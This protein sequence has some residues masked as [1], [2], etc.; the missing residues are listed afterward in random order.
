[1]EKKLQKIYLTYYNLLIAQDLW[2]AHYQILSI[3]FLKEFIKLNVNMDTIIQNVKNVKL[4][5]KI[6][7]VL[8][9]PK[10]SCCNKIY[11]Q[12]FD[13][14]LKEQFFNIY[15]FPNHNNNDFSLLL[16]KGIYPYDK[17]HG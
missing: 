3:I 10:C 2:Q 16:Q 13:E 11:Q 6:A 14:K 5:I 15:K 4:N 17:N 7:I 9:E 1:M 12:K 8:I